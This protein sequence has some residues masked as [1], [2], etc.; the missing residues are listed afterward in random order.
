M[1]IAT[2]IL[3]GIFQ[4]CCLTSLH[5]GGFLGMCEFDNAVYSPVAYEM[6]PIFLRSV[7]HFAYSALLQPSPSSLISSET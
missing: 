5:L 1:L 2:F 6:V 3:L 4:F 7:E